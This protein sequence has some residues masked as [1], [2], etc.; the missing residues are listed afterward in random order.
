M[1]LRQ[2]IDWTKRHHPTRLPARIDF[3]Y[4]V[5][6]ERNSEPRPGVAAPQLKA[7]LRACYE[8]IDEAWKPL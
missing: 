6:P 7:I 8:E 1:Q 5:Y 3:P 2:L 4:R